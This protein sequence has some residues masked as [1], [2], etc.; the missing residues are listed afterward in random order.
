MPR[1]TGNRISVL[2]GAAAL[3]AAFM[4][5][6]WVL[7]E[8]AGTEPGSA[9]DPLVSRSY[10]DSKLQALENRIQILEARVAQLEKGGGVVVAPP[11]GGSTTPVPVTPD[12]PTPV[13]AVYPRPERNWCNVRAQASTAAALVGQCPRGSSMT[14]L[15]TSGDWFQVRLNNG[16]TGWVHNS[17]AELR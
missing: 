15:K 11:T 12:S 2:L 5:G 9:A 16:T 4:L 1:M 10:V 7:A 3:L 13:R 8:G 17:V 6:G 14:W